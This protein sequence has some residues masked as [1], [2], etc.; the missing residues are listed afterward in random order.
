VAV[1]IIASI[2]DPVAIKKILERLER[3]TDSAAD[4]RP[5]SRAPPEMRLFD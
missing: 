3:K 1:R 4:F 2:E 5:R